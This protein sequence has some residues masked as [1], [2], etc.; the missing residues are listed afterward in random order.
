[1]ILKSVETRLTTQKITTLLLKPFIH[2]N[3][4]RIIL[5]PFVSHKRFDNN[6]SYPQENFQVYLK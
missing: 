3:I 2:K 6:D 4:T 1:M 5:F